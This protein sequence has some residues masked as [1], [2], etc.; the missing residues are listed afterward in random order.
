[1]QEQS[2]QTK[3]S[4]SPSPSLVVGHLTFVHQGD[5]GSRRSK[6]GLQLV[7]I[8]VASQAN[9]EP[10]VHPDKSIS[11]VEYSGW[12][13]RE[14][15]SARARTLSPAPLPTNADGLTFSRRPIEAFAVVR[16]ANAIVLVALG[17]DEEEISGNVSL[18]GTVVAP[19]GTYAIHVTDAKVGDMWSEQLGFSLPSTLQ[20]NWREI[21]LSRRAKLEAEQAEERRER[22]AERLAAEEEAERSSEAEKT[23]SEFDWKTSTRVW[24]TKDQVVVQQLIDSSRHYQPRVEPEFDDNDNPIGW[25]VEDQFGNGPSIEQEVQRIRAER[26]DAADAYFERLR[27]AA[28]EASQ[29]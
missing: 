13:V 7:P 12:E 27:E 4:S 5:P 10:V 26:G 28:Y 1:M 20:P 19:A 17:H 15:S 11:M 24:R 18:L 8:L 9:S 22:E 16:Q 3:D 2:K 14:V 25:V 23:L 6:T 29:S 21:A